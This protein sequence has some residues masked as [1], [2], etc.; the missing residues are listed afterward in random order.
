MTVLGAASERMK[1]QALAEALATTPG[2]VSQVVGPLVKAGWVRSEPG[3][4]GGY[5]LRVPL[6]EVCVLDVIEAIDGATDA[7]RCV[8]EA[9]SCD[10]AMPCILHL[11]WNRARAELVRT[12]GAMSLSS[13]ANAESMPVAVP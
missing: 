11:A 1:G 12:L 6:D 10:S 5:A 8:V 9:R 2:F 4:T 7:G 13:L 3:P